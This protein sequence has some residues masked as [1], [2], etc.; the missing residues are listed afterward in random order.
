MNATVK[1]KNLWTEIWKHRMVYTLLI[2][3]FVWYVIFD[4]GPMAGLQLAF[5]DY[6]ANLGIWG[7]EW[8]GLE[9]FSYVF[10]E[11][12]FYEAILKSITLNLGRL[13]CTFPAP[14]ILAL[15]LNELRFIKLKRT[16]Q[17]VLTFPHFLSWVVMSG[18]IIN[19]LGF[20]GLVDSILRSL[21]GEGV[22]I[23]AN[24][25]ATIPLLYLSGIWKESGY[26][27][28]IYL[29]AI[30]SIE[31]EQYES[32]VIDGANRFQ[33]ILYITFPNI[34]PIITLMLVMNMGSLLSG[35]FDQIFNLQ[36]AATRNV[37]ETLDLYIYRITFD[38]PPDYGFST[39][40]SLFRSIIN[41]GFLLASD[42]IAKA[43]G[44][45]GLFGR[46]G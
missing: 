42:R 16:I 20:S 3:A 1:K 13:V 22:N 24:P 18:V 28:I 26:G 45:D 32:A 43:L 29:A 44:G 6:K 33:K 12:A 9:N 11:R 31:Q 23:M 5:K 2:P 14:I 41:M 36:N 21:G 38:S 10:K 25:N 39:A 4:Y 30:A 8:V 35:N 19:F 15:A 27:T 46:R 7:S 34:L 40:I 37:V 17:T